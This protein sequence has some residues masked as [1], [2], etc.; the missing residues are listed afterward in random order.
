VLLAISTSGNSRKVMRAVETARGQGLRTL[1]FLGR[2]GG[3]L[4]QLVDIALVVPSTHTQRIQ[5]VHITVGHIVCGAL[6]RRVV[7]MHGGPCQHSAAF[8]ATA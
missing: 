4:R 8:E 7:T 3:A 6:E 2:D 5:E 1:G